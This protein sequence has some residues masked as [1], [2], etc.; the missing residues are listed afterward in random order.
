MSICSIFFNWIFFKAMW[1]YFWVL[2]CIKVSILMSKLKCWIYFWS[3]IYVVIQWF[4]QA[5]TNQAGNRLGA[6]FSLENIPAQPK[7]II[8]I[9]HDYQ[10]NSEL[11]P[12]SAINS[13]RIC[14]WIWTSSMHFIGTF[15]CLWRALSQWLEDNAIT[16]KTK[17]IF[18]EDRL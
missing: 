14:H 8:I 12:T 13:M 18:F 9:Q 11:F 6:Y 5:K 17:S 4:T 16:L 7:S 15:Y 1:I 3:G 2:I 10:F